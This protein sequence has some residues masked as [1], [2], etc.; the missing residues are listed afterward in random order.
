MA[1]YSE[2]PPFPRG[3]TALANLGQTLTSTDA[4]QWLG[5]VVAFPN[6]N[7]A[8]KPATP[9]G[10]GGDIVYCLVVRNTSGHKLLP[11]FL[12]Q[13]SPTFE[14]AGYTA[15]GGGEGYPIDEFLNPTDGVPVNDL[16]YVVIEGPARCLLDIAATNGNLL[17]VGD[18]IAALTAAASTAATSGA[19][20]N[21]ITAGRVQMEAG[22]VA[23]LLASATSGVVNISD[24]IQKGRNVIG[25]AMSAATTNS[26]GLAASG[27]P[28]VYVTQ[29]W[30]W[31]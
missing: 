29:R 26:T 13:V 30:K 10:G 4:A 2:A 3:T 28:L 22:T 14:C 15:S 1:F 16:F 5:R 8:A 27:S 20:S 11:K 24:V 6:F 7:W 17:A 21:N 31:A 12:A 18:W 25:K 23:A 9:R 19:T